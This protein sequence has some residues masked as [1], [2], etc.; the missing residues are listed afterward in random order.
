MFVERN[1]ENLS[2][3]LE[4]EYDGAALPQHAF[5]HQTDF[6]G[7]ST[8]A[9]IPRRSTETITAGT[10]NRVPMLDIRNIL[11]RQDPKLVSTKETVGS[12]GKG[13]IFAKDIAS[14]HLQKRPLAILTA[15]CIDNEH[16]PAATTVL[17]S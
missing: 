6:G 7:L 10:V 2:Q 8:N 3:A 12:A 5:L 16:V 1:D 13:T 14:N 4:G 11:Q 15:G 9:H 17:C